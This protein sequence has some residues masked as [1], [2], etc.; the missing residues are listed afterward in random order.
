M[1]IGFEIPDESPKEYKSMPK[2]LSGYWWETEHLIT[3]PFIES[4]NEGDGTFTKWLTGLETK[5]KVIFFPTVISARLDYILRKHNYTDAW[6][7]AHDM[8]NEIVDGLAKQC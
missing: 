2:E 8:N 7:V 3:I 4:R 1:V 6:T 5:G